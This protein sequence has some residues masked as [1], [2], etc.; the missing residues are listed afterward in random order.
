MTKKKIIET[1][2]KDIMSKE[3][4]K[5]YAKEIYHTENPT[6][7]T[8]A[9]LYIRQFL[10]NGA[11]GFGMTRVSENYT[12]LK[13]I[14]QKLIAYKLVSRNAYNNSGFPLWNNYDF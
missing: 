5:E 8:I 10:N 14:K 2:L 6:K 11:D 3:D 12:F 4:K 13:S 1:L 9:D 7:Y